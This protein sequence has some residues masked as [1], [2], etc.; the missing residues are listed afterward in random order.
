MIRT[1][2]AVE[3]QKP[4]KNG[5]KWPILAGCTLDAKS[6][7]IVVKLRGAVFRD[8]FSL[9]IEY[10][11]SLLARDLGLECAEVVAVEVDTPFAAS[12]E[13][14]KLPNY[15]RVIERSLGTNVGSIFLG[16]GF[17]A[18]LPSDKEKAR[19][20]KT[21][22]QITAFDFL[23]QNL[24]RQPENPNFLRKGKR[25]LLID[26]EQ[27]FGHLD[28]GEDAPFALER[29]KIEAFLK[30]VFID[31]V[32]LASDFEPLFDRLAALSDATI[33]AYINGLPKV[34][35]DIRTERLTTYL[36]WIRDHAP[37]IRDCLRTYIAR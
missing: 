31:A 28:N 15:A 2:R 10:V 29:L 7:D 11:A 21:L 9:A 18:A 34:W 12:A 24:D 35:L 8:T 16:S 20:R 22:T 23:I 13:A 37:E 32:D 5:S 6:V 1:A 17:N 3:F 33:S 27:A 4:M 25:V 30:H 14:A 19:F 36:N 26:H